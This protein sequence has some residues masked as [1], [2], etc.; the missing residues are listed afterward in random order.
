[1]SRKLAGMY[2]ITPETDID[3]LAR[4]IT[5]AV[6][7]AFA[8]IGDDSGHDVDEDDGDDNDEDEADGSA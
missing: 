7:A 5:A 8:D 4:Q 3:A 2:G 6:R 1:M